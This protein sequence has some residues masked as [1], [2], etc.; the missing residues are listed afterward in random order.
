[1]VSIVDVRPFP[2]DHGIAK[3]VRSA[4]RVD[5]HLERHVP[6]RIVCYGSFQGKEG[7]GSNSVAGMRI[8]VIAAPGMGI[9]RESQPVTRIDLDRLEQTGAVD[10]PHCKELEG[11]IAFADAWWIQ[12]RWLFGDDLD[13]WLAPS[14]A[15]VGIPRRPELFVVHIEHSPIAGFIDFAPRHLIDTIRPM[16]L[17]P[18]AILTE[19]KAGIL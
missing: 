17:T 13:F 8:I 12:K 4:G 14:V 10:P 1:M 11:I 6:L 18:M 2:P 7:S 9:H 15:I 19:F 5:P 3:R 16:D